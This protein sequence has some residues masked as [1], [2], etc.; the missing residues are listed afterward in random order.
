M[1]KFNEIN[2]NKISVYNSIINSAELNWFNKFYEY[3]KHQD[4]FKKKNISFL[5]Y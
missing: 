4:F 2:K 1:Y 5:F 3:L